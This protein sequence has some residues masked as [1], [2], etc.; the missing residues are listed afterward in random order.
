MESGILFPLNQL[1][2]AV[3]D[4]LRNQQQ[5]KLSKVAF[6]I[7]TGRI[8]LVA[9]RHR[10]AVGIVVAT[11]VELGGVCETGLST[12]MESRSLV[13]VWDGLS[14]RSSNDLVSV[15]SQRRERIF[16]RKRVS[17]LLEEEGSFYT[18]FERHVD[19]NGFCWTSL[20]GA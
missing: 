17:P 11:A 6:T 15:C 1:W 8:R 12:K 5:H 20:H 9:G 2:N 7:A 14:G 3:A 4:W 16:T 10:L 18:W 13:D 19:L